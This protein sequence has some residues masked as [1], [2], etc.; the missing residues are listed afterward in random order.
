MNRNTKYKTSYDEY[1]GYQLTKDEQ[2]VNINVK[3]SSGTNDKTYTLTI[4][5]ANTSLESVKVN[6][7]EEIS[8]VKKELING[9]TADVYE[10][11]VNADKADLYVKAISDKALV[12]VSLDG[13]K[14]ADT[15]SNIWSVSGYEIMMT[16]S[17]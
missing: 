13:A 4:Y 12:N 8:N 15:A 9:S 16:I 5:R 1:K 6:D 11:T 3:P 10:A 17:C 7:T 14:A 2:N